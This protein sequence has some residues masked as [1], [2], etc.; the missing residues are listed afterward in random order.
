MSADH[1]AWTE[2]PDHEK[3]LRHRFEETWSWFQQSPLAKQNALINVHLQK[4]EVGGWLFE[5]RPP[6]FDPCIKE[7]KL[8]ESGKYNLSVSLT[9]ANQE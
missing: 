9:Y 4:L 3:Q 6:V 8:D 7:V 1:C 2:D 5:S